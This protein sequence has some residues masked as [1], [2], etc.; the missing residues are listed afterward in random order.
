MYILIHNLG[1]TPII[2]PAF[3]TYPFDPR[4]AF[5]SSRAPYP[6]PALYPP[7]ILYWSYP[8][9]P[10]SPTTYFAHQPAGHPHGLMDWNPMIESWNT[11]F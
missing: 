2:A 10:V 1:G 7:P 11:S 4:A 3:G 9:P 5:I 8:S 6:G